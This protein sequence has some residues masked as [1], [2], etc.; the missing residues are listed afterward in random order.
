[1][2]TI[3]GFLVFTI[4]ITLVV[5]YGCSGTR[6]IADLDD[7]VDFAQIKTF[8]FY[9]WTEGSDSV[10]NRFDKERIEQSFNEEA[11]KRGLTQVESNGDAIISLYLTWEIKTQQ[12][13]TTT[14]SGMIAPGMGRLGMRSPGWGWGMGHSV[15]QIQETRYVDGTIMIE[16]FDPDTKHLIWQAIGTKRVTEDPQKKAKDIPKKIATIM[17]SYPVKPIE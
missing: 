4:N 17:D 8:E 10:L 6:V 16:M 3:R 15:T 1:M 11:K 9:G 2:S 7:T 5:L 13:A 14:S 12:T